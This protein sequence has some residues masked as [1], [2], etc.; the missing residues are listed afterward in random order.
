MKKT[1]LILVIILFSLLA[2]TVSGAGFI[3][4]SSSGSD[5]LRSTGSDVD[6]APSG[7]TGDVV[8]WSLIDAGGGYYYIQN[9]D[10]SKRLRATS[11]TA[12]DLANAG[13]TG[14]N[15]EWSIV[16]WDGTWS[17][18]ISRSEGQKMHA[19]SSEG[20]N[21]NLV[22]SN[23]TGANVQ[24]KYVSTSPEVVNQSPP[25][26]SA[27]IDPNG[28][29]S[30]STIN[31]TSPIFEISIGTDTNCNDVLVDHNTLSAMNYTPTA[32]LLDN[33]TKY[34][35]RVDIHDG[36]TEYAGNPISFTTYGT[37][38]DPDPAD[39]STNVEPVG[40]ASWIGD[41]LTASYDVYFS[42]VGQS[43]TYIDNYTD[44]NVSLIELA[45][46]I[47][48]GIL[49]SNIEYQW[50][51]DTRDS[52][53]GLLA[54][55]DL[56]SFTVEE[57]YGTYKFV[58]DDF[59][60]YADT[61]ELQAVWSE[62]SSAN[63][64]AEPL[65]NIM[66][67][68]YNNTLSPY[69]SEATMNISP[70]KDWGELGVSSLSF[71]LLGATMNST[72]QVYVVVGDGT[73]SHKIWLDDAVT[74]YNDN[75]QTLSLQ[76]AELEDN[77]V[78]LSNVTTLIIGLGDGVLAGGIGT[79]FINDIFLYPMRCLSEYADVA[80]VMG[81]CKVDIED[82]AI[83][84]NDWLFANFSVASVAPVNSPSVHYDFNETSG[85]TANDSS[86]NNYD[87]AIEPDTVSGFRDS[88]GLSGYCISLTD[89]NLE[90]NIPAAVFSGISNK[91]TVSI[92]LYGEANSVPEPI[93]TV[94]VLAGAAYIEDPNNDWDRMQ[95][96][97][98]SADQY[99]SNWNHYALVK[100]ADANLMEIYVNGILVAR[101]TD[102]NQVMSGSIAGATILT[103]SPGQGATTVK[104]DELKIFNAALT[105]EEIVYLA[106]GSGGFATQD[107]APV[108]TD[109][110]I[111]TDGAVNLK[112]LAQ[113]ASAWLDDQNW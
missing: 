71:K 50:Q 45:N 12:V 16:D 85:Y 30:W 42:E 100:D 33:A 54:T 82:L 21:V 112:D 40:N 17:F 99:E 47:G 104:V 3:E 79:V 98:I 109:A 106:K 53:G 90:V 89:P 14:T 37:A 43:L 103:M 88:A 23:W 35:W 76:L 63:I 46:G 27:H 52:G 39:D 5:R 64:E 10:N 68:D 110:D 28:T 91:L 101:K 1:G 7:T 78:D 8:L 22:A 24:W 60:D 84:T 41:A 74:D 105:Q 13:T 73:T 38:S 18:I 57:Y 75:W 70:A 58:V 2:Y 51:V 95:W 94:E 92:W 55:G 6:L 61:N 20:W 62:S 56:W 80:D 69:E 97:I 65:T 77:G 107:I 26:N 81:D 59:F 102:A 67:L 87:A 111:I 49:Q 113:L 83:I 96:D 48:I 86:G 32:G 31:T 11:S 15:V 66:Q 29:L 25:N 34:Y 19:K 108:L 9:I 36:G 72:E 4:Q 44:A 93:E